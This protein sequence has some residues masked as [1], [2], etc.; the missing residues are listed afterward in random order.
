MPELIAVRQANYTDYLDPAIVSR[1]TSI[2]RGHAGSKPPPSGDVE[3]AADQ[4]RSSIIREL[5]DEEENAKKADAATAAA[6]DAAAKRR[7]ARDSRAKASKSRKPD[8]PDDTASH[9]QKAQHDALVMVRDVRT[10]FVPGSKLVHDSATH[11][12]TQPQ[13]QDDED[14]QLCVVCLAHPRSVLLVPCGH[15]VLC[16]SCYAG[17][18]DGNNECPM[19]RGYIES[20]LTP[21]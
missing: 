5:L 15:F 12:A 18:R 19:C 7:K 4:H 13:S 16:Q 20:T 1:V 9:E 21:A 6:A 10:S 17:I 11:G 3:D 14:E 8:S 2:P